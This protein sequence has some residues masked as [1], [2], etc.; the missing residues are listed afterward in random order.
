MDV[1][2]PD[3]GAAVQ[4]YRQ[5]RIVFCAV[6]FFKGNQVF[7]ER[8]PHSDQPSVCLHMLAPNAEKI[9]ALSGM[10][11][12]GYERIV[13]VSILRRENMEKLDRYDRI[14]LTTLQKNGRASNVELSEQASLSAP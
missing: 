11:Q 6:P 4:H 5:G 3:A 13:C 8:S 14:L 10:E 9:C 12:M 2:Q 1:G 7:H